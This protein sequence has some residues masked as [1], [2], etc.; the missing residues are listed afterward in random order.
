MGLI[1]KMFG[2]YSDRQLK[3]LEQYVD[4]IESLAPKYAAMTNE[5]LAGTTA[6]L[7]ERLAKGETLDD[8]MADAFAAQAE[9]LARMAVEDTGFGNV[10]DKTEKNRFASQQV[11]QAIAPMRTVGV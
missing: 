5:E 8:I 7:K 3:K 9:E 4:Y 6:L 11:L 1:K 10:A 2:T